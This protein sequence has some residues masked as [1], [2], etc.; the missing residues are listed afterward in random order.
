MERPDLAGHLHHVIRLYYIQLLYLVKA[1]KH[2]SALIARLY[3][4][5][6]ILKS[7]QGCQR[8]L[9]DLSALTADAHLAASLKYAVHHIGTGNI[10][11]LGSLEDLAHLRVTDNLLLKDRIQHTLHGRLH[12]LDGLINHT[13]QSHVNALSLRRSLCRSVGSYIEADNYGVGCAGQRH[14][15]FINSAN[16]SM[17]A[18]YY[19]FFI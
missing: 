2:K 15:G 9:I 19:Y 7:L 14:I 1:F 12:I 16:A 11:D 5:Y 17:D 6:I 8:T 3:F 13:I 10:A 4:L 18:F